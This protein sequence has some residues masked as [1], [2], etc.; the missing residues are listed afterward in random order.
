MLEQRHT[1]RDKSIN[2]LMAGRSYWSAVDAMISQ[3]QWWWWVCD[4]CGR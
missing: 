2:R 3:A 4:G 1:I